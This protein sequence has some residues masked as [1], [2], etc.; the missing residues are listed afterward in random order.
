VVEEYKKAKNGILLGME[1]FGEGIDIP[2][3]GLQF[4]FIDKIP[5]IRMELVI[6]KRR[7]FY[8][9]NFGNEFQ[10]YFMASRMRGLQQKLGRLLRRDSDYGGAIIVDA[11]IKKWQGKTIHALKEMALPYDLRTD[12]FKNACDEVARFII[13]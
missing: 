3:E 2:G 12:S 7:E 13:R 5:D 6:K 4:V 8:D 9:Q 11:R 1:S 10:D